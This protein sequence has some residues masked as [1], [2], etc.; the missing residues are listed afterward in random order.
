MKLDKAYWE[1]KYTT[2]NLGWDIGHISTPLKSYI[3]QIKD[4]NLKIL[5]PGAGKG[6]EAIYLFQQGFTNI[7]VMDIA[8]R[9]L[10]HIKL[11]VPYFPADRLIEGDFFGLRSKNFD[12]V[13]EQTFFCALPPSLR[14]EYVLKMKSIL[15]QGGKLVGLL[16]DFPLTEN[17]PPFGGSKLEYETLFGPHFDISVLEPAYNSIK[18]RLGKELFFIFERK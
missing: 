10:E 11:K 8:S 16:F 2:D 4:K 9:P 7:F 18:P 5:I 13:L 14:N 15:E 6:Y 17:G 1:S 3:D 12:L